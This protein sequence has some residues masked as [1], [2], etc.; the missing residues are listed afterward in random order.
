MPT[1]EF[2]CAGCTRRRD[3]RAGMGES[4]ELVLVCL[5]CGGD[6]RKGV[7]RTV[8][9]VR[10]D[11]AS[12]SVGGAGATPRSRRRGRTCT[13]GSVKLTRP[14]PFAAELPVPGKEAA[15]S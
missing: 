3:V 14:N 1:Y 2:A 12:T 8:A 10:S 7:P 13:G 6:M 5:D 9:V 4:D 15:G 11:S